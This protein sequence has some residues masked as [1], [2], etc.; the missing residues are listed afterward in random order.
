MSNN[1]QR[2]EPD[3]GSDELLDQSYC[4]EVAHLTAPPARDLVGRYLG[5]FLDGL[6]IT[7]T[8]LVHS[9]KHQK[10]LSS[11]GRILFN[12]VDKVATLQARHKKIQPSVRLR[13]LDALITTGIK[14]VWDDE[15]ERPVPSVTPDTFMAVIGKLKTTAPEREYAINRI[16]TELLFPHKVWKDKVVVLD[17]LMRQCGDTD[18][19]PLIELPLAECLRSEAAMDQLLG[20][21]DRLEDRCDDLIAL[22]NG[23]WTPRDTAAEVV[24]D[25]AQQIGSGKAPNCK[26]AVEHALLRA[27]TGKLPLRSAE[28]EQEIQA[29]FDMFRRMW[30][31]NSLIGGA[32]ALAMLEKRQAR[33]INSETITDLLR[34]R[35]VLADRICYLM[36]MTGIAIGQSNRAT[37]KAFIDHY[38]GDQDFLPRVIAGQDSPVPKLQTLTQTHRLIRSSWLSDEDKASHMTKVEA[39]QGELLRRSRLLEQVEKK[40]GGAAQKLLTLVELCRKNTFIEGTV[41]EAIKKAIIGYLQTPDFLND[42]LAGAQGEDKDRKVALLSKTLAS[43]GIRWGN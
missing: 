22:W 3:Q 21:S 7:P 36:T 39:A 26:A 5:S 11:A 31:N 17:K 24:G 8:E 33:N 28:P 9:A 14:K 34:E 19:L 13:E 10:R 18:I 27:L 37:L 1:N 6:I 30:I 29:V 23:T 35:K 15:K 2:E 40:G 32:K 4:T 41:L 16:I 43:F 12:A 42:Y 20:L 38:F 25:L